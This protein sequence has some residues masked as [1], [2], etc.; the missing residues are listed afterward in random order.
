MKRRKWGG[1][2]GFVSEPR[3]AP[4]SGRG[5]RGRCVPSTAWPAGLQGSLEK[6]ARPGTSAKRSVVLVQVTNNLRG[7]LFKSS[8]AAGSFIDE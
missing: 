6:R 1:V 3:Q 4:A 7:N 8:P 2:R 5:T